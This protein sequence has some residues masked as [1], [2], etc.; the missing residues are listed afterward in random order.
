MIPVVILLH[1]DFGEHLLD[2]VLVGFGT[3][4]A[5]LLFL[6]AIVPDEGDVAD[7]LPKEFDLR[8]HAGLNG[9][10]NRG[11][12]RRLCPVTFFSYKLFPSY[13]SYPSLGRVRRLKL[14]T[15]FL[16]TRSFLPFMPPKQ[17]TR[18]LSAEL[19]FDDGYDG[20]DG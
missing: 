11:Q 15:L 14:Q 12:V 7:V 5:R 18:F 8:I 17:N 6:P 16:R 3:M 20:N 9:A 19:I 4:L 2:E 10:L 13:P 1:P